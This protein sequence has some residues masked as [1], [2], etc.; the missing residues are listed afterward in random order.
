MKRLIPFLAVSLLAGCA[1]PTVPE[2]AITSILTHSGGQ[3]QGDATSLYWYSFQQNRPLKL[4]EVV[5]IGANGRYQSD[6]RWR[7]GRLR[8]IK[9]SGIR[10]SGNALKPFTLHVRY[11]T[12]GSAVFQRYTVDG[13]VLPL[14]DPQLY[15]LTQQAENAVSM[16]KGQHKKDQSLIQGYWQGERFLRCGDAKPLEVTFQPALSEQHA[17]QLSQQPDGR[18]MVVT[19]KVRR[20]QLVASQLLILADEARDCITPPNLLGN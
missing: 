19:G 5:T 4:A 1:T 12:R 11:D 7:E 16:V 8:E 20:N 3:S 2:N 15:R 10:Q 9:R 13:T 14:T 17:Y 18:F 6:Y